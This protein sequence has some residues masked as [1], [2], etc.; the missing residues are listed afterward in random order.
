MTVKTTTQRAGSS[1]KLVL[2]ADRAEVRGDVAEGVVGIAAQSRDRRDADH[3][4]QGEHDR[5]LDDRWSVVIPQKPTRLFVEPVHADPLLF[6]AALRPE[7]GTANR[8]LPDL[9]LLKGKARHRPNDP[10]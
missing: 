5:V 10:D 7:T 1:Y 2:A 9:R 4:D 3:D 6:Q 8:P